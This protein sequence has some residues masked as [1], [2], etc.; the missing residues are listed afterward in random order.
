M[1]SADARRRD[2]K[3]EDDEAIAEMCAN[4]PAKRV[5]YEAPEYPVKNQYGDTFISVR[6]MEVLQFQI[7]I[8]PPDEPTETFLQ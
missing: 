5:I 7:N 2:W 8:W 4:D 3:G 1:Q 6:P